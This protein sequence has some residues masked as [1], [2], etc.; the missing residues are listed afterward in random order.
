MIMKQKLFCLTCALLF[1]L[2]S[3]VCAHA[4][5]VFKEFG[6]DVKAATKQ[7]GKTGKDVGKSIGRTGK[8][9]GKSVSKATKDL[10]AD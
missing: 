1:G 7:A 2:A 3:G 4:D 10:F 6:R 5:N 8:K 9:V